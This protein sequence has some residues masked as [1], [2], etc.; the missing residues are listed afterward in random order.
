LAA[1]N[2]Y[3][4]A[5]Q[6]DSGLALVTLFNSPGGASAVTSWTGWGSQ[7]FQWPS[8]IAVNQVSG[9]PVS[10]YVYVLDSGTCA[11]SECDSTTGSA[12]Y[13]FNSS[14]APTAVTS[15]TKYGSMSFNNPSGLAMDTN[16]NLYVADMNNYEVEEFGSGGATLGEWN[17][18]GNAN[19][20]PAA[21]AVDGSNN[22]Y[23]VDA[24]NYYVWE[25]PS[26]G[27]TATSWPLAVQGNQ[28][29]PDYGLTVDSSGNVYVAD[30]YNSLVEVYNNSGALIGEMNGN[31]GSSTPFSG[32]DVILLFNGNIYVGD[33]DNDNI[34]IFGPNTY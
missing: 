9:S 6:A 18:G 21:V 14:A 1:G 30:Y 31:F 28:E 7:S 25:L 10:G 22:I 19:F 20:W 23:V 32:P 34:Q 27:G 5:A 24:G 29:Y 17:A 4:Y 26:I 33:Y 2:G 11:D 15:W 16:G 3:L 13:V 12:V 8:G